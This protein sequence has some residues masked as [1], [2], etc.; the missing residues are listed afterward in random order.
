MCKVLN[1]S[2][3]EG[4][5]KNRYIANIHHARPRSETEDCKKIKHD[6][7]N[8]LE[9]CSLVDDSIVRGTTSKELVKMAREAGAKEVYFASAAPPVIFSNVWD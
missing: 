2:Y 8:L 7:L 1:L 9:E 4:F 3:R 5:V 6:K